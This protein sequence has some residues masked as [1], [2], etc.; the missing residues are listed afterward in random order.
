MV[1]DME[2]YEKE[3]QQKYKQIDDTFEFQFSLYQNDLF[4]FEKDGVTVERVFRGD[5][6]PRQNKIEVDYTFKK[7]AEQ[8]EGFLA[9]S[10]IS[11]A[12]KYNV[13][14]LG[15]RHKVVEEKFNRYLQI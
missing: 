4:E 12:V 1:L 5:N 6:N 14:V 8:K 11:N 2:K 3:K 15:N 9:P 7:K 13:D 10:T